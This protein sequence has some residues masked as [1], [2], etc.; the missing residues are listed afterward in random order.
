[1]VN[2]PQIIWDGNHVPKLTIFHLDNQI[3][4]WMSVE[5]L[6]VDA[7]EPLDKPLQ[8]F[9]NILYL[10]QLRLLL[11]RPLWNS[12]EE[13]LTET[14]TTANI[15]LWIHYCPQTGKLNGINITKNLV[16]FRTAIAEKSK[17]CSR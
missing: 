5:D 15:N 12:V 6:R 9:I 3:Y 17:R 10:S 16:K 4:L 2:F 13:T 14:S 11:D 7:G 1:M 8:K